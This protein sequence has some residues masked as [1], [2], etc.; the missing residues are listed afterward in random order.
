MTK[1]AYLS[2]PLTLDHRISYHAER[3]ARMKREA[4]AVYSLWGEHIGSGGNDA[5]YVRMMERI[6]ELEAKMTE[7]C[8]LYDRLRA[9][10]E[11]VIMR[12][13]EEKMQLVLLYHYLEGMSFTQIGERLFMDRGTAFRWAGRGLQRLELPE[14][15]VTIYAE[16]CNG[17]L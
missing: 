10:V 7:E 17:C 6:Q 15:P 12:L 4:D 13:P 1:K 8:A 3:L 9:Q 14:E 5:P 16:L 11:A 2:Q